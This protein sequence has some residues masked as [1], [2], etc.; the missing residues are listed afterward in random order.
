VALAK[1]PREY[2]GGKTAAAQQHFAHSSLTDC[3]AHGIILA[4]PQNPEIPNAKLQGRRRSPALCKTY[5]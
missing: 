1:Y 2:D 4:H 5:E 3:P